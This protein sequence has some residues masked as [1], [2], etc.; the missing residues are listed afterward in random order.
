MSGAHLEHDWFPKPLPENVV[1][2]ERT[3]LYSSFAFRHY[4]SSRPA[5][6]RAGNDT[7]LYNGTFFDLGPDG[8]VTI[9]DYSS[10]VGAIICCN[11]RVVI[12]D[13][14]FIAHEVVL[15]DSFAAVPFESRRL[16][17]VRAE[18]TRSQPAI[19]IADKVWIGA[20]AIILAGARI[21]QG[22][23]VGAAAV[24]DFDVPPYTVVAG[25]PARIVKSIRAET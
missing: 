6:V 4:Q 21:G 12:G 22:A 23:I 20:R 18:M 14:V 9:G 15:A 7:G 25:N 13:Y 11:G 24:V 16:P 3:W 8:E 10:L 5:G 1:L 17:N 19:S 2:G